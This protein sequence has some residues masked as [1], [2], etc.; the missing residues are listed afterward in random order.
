[1]FNLKIVATTDQSTQFERPLL[2]DEQVD[3]NF[4]FQ[5][6]HKGRIKDFMKNE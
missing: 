2:L 1:M 5:L 4:K 3:E 6:K